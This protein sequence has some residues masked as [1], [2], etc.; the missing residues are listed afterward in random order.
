MRASLCLPVCLSAFTRVRL[1]VKVSMTRVNPRSM[2]DISGLE[3]IAINEQRLLK[4]SLR[5]SF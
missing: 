5:M 1:I 4:K 2:P 3:D